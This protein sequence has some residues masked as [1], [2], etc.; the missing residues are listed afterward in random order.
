[1]P[2]SASAADDALAHRLQVGARFGGVEQLRF[3]PLRAGRLEGV[4]ELGE[5]GPQQLQ[6]GVAVGQ[7][8]VLVGGDVRE[9][10]H[11]RAH[12]RRV[13]ALELA[14]VEVG[15][16]LQRAAA[17]LVQGRE[18]LGRWGRGVAAVGWETVRAMSSGRV[19][20]VGP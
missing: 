17:G 11:E 12:D 6:A 3:A 15:H 9:V 2:T 1:M 7:P 13:R 5:V 8:Q 20:K 16:Q 4:V 14:V 19:L 18:R 10:P